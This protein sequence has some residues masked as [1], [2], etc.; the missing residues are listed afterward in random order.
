[1]RQYK[2]LLGFTLIEIMLVLA[3]IAALIYLG[4]GYYQQ[5]LQN[6]RVEKT[7]VQMQQILNAA[8]AFY[9]ANGRWPASTSE[10][11]S[12]NYLPLSPIPPWPVPP[13]YQ[14]YVGEP[15]KSNPQAAIFSLAFVLPASLP[16]NVSWAQVLAGKLPLAYTSQYLNQITACEVGKDCAVIAQVTIPGQNLNNAMAMNFAGLYH[17]GACVPAPV[18]PETSPSG[19]NMTPEIFLVPVSVRGVYIP[20]G[21]TQ[22]SPSQLTT[23][24]GFT[25]Y[26]TGNQN[27]A[28]TNSS[29]NQPVT[30][31]NGGPAL[32]T[33][34][35]IQ[36]NPPCGFS[37]T[38]GLSYWRACLQLVTGQGDVSNLAPNNAGWGSQ[39]T[40][41]AFTRCAISGEPAGSPSTVYEN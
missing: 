1:M 8:L 7:A 17:P 14:A 16:N 30:I 2:R 11:V 33:Q 39:I 25:A 4:T 5:Q 35:P 6:S 23:I 3:I 32:C 13:P 34:Q 36:N 37:D 27:T 10:L 29:Y 38:T 12:D 31:A 26:A 24:N 15:I 18:C 21:A 28:N 40:M 19:A 22:V 41:A 9:V 20:G